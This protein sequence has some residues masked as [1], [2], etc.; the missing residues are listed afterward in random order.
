MA[1]CL[2][3][4]GRWL[5]DRLIGCSVVGREVVCLV[6]GWYIGWSVVGT[7]AGRWLVHWQV[8]GWY[9]GR[10]VVGTLAGRWL[11]HWQVGGW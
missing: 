9:I 7:L 11:V 4:F 10:S 8:G 2:A 1:R 6:G 5:L 3:G